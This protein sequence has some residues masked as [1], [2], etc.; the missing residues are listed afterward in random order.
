MTT[1]SL[2]QRKSLTIS[3]NYNSIILTSLQP[4][5]VDLRYFQKWILL[6]QIVK[7]IQHKVENR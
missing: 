7:V 1:F 5:V 4:D 2:I 6:D 3:L